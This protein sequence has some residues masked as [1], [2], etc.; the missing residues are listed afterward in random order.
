MFDRFSEDARKV[1]VSAQEEARK[2][3]HK[4]IGSEHILLGLSLV[5]EGLASQALASFDINPGE[6]RNAIITI[7]GSTFQPL[8]G[9][10]PFSPR[11]KKVLELSLREALSLAHNYIGT[12]H[13]LLG[14]L[15]EGDSTAAQ[16]LLSLGAELPKLRDA[17]LA[18]LALGE[19][20]EN[21]ERE[22]VFS[23]EKKSDILSKNINAFGVDL[24]EEVRLGK[25]DPVI[26]REDEIERVI[27]ILSRR[28]KNNPIL[29]GEPGV[30]KTA[31]IEGLAAR[32]IAGDVPLALKDAMVFSV[33]LGSLIAGSR[34]RGDF[35]ERF[36]KLISE[37]E[38]K[39][40]IILFFDEIHT[41]IGAGGSDGSVDAANMM[42]PLLSRGNLKTIGATTYDEFK[43]KFSKDAA[44]LR[45]FQTVDVNPP[46]VEDT[47]KILQGLRSNYQDFHHVEITDLALESAVKLSNRYI[48]DRF[49]PDKAIDV[50]DEAAARVKVKGEGLS[51]EHLLVDENAVSEVVSKWTGVPVR[52]ISL[53]E[54]E[55]FAKLESY[56]EFSVV[57]QNDAVASLAKSVRRSKAGLKDPNRPSGSFIFAGPT[58]VGKTQLAKSLAEALFGSSE[59]IININM[60]EYMEKHTVSRLLGSP[61]G[62]VGFDEGGQLTERVRRKPFSVILFDEIEK[63]HPDIF[64][65]LLQVLDEG[66]LTDS[67]GKKV[68]F[69]NTYIILTTNL[70]SKE[71]AKA[72]GLGFAHESTSQRERLVNAVN[73]ELKEYFRPEFLNRIDD[74]IVFN[75]LSFVDIC[76]IVELQLDKLQSR[77][78]ERNITLNVSIGAKEKLA[79]LGFDPLLGVRPLK[80]TIQNH[81][82]DKLAELI[83]SH[84][85]PDNSVVLVD[86]FEND[87]VLTISPTIEVEELIVADSHGND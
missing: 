43:K 82:E 86:I 69:R 73:H 10:I 2:L 83:I 19:S 55:K 29:I 28:T 79:T 54:S 35:E 70:G 50:L 26:G 65:T 21:F 18:L 47:I 72:N 22:E 59:D 87:F 15:R 33:V 85:L 39:K 81:I 1:V 74:I 61:P 49:L 38:K 46:S 30:G 5:E 80:R 78:G 9:H 56:L 8:Q 51:A 6:I 45:R 20:N 60:S 3:G 77:L 64:N 67:S 84:Q 23:H 42:K 16:I 11:S 66:T 4:N 48:Q 36:K 31:I 68:D 32:I 75:Q 40:N 57:G 71:L 13:I 52:Q 27:Q 7:K 17:I 12:E 41:L 24:T 63:A 14:I 37:V 53:E 25:I 76:H 34:Y 58:G 62:Y 44:M